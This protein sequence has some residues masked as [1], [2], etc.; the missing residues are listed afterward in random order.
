MAATDK[1]SI[2]MTPEARANA[3]R[4]IAMAERLGVALPNLSAIVRHALDVAAR[5]S[6]DGAAR[7]RDARL[8]AGL[9][10]RELADVAG[11]SPG[12]VRA[13][14]CGRVPLYK[15]GALAAWLAARS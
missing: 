14:E 6:S 10:P 8:S 5:A 4:V 15:H 2:V 11:C 1:P 3:D 9:T 13:V 7:V 12:H